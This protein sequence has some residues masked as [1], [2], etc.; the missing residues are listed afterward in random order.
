MLH[1]NLLEY[2][3]YIKGICAGLKIPDTE[4]KGAPVSIRKDDI[5]HFT[6]FVVYLRNGEEVEVW[7]THD[8]I[9]KQWECN[10]C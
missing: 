5:T 9:L 4:H 3:T 1:L 7:E 6:N 8:E 2:D 10:K